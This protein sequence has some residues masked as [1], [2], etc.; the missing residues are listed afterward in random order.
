MEK[1]DYRVYQFAGIEGKIDRWTQEELG[2][3]DGLFEA[4]KK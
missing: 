1:G 4:E 3:E 2:R